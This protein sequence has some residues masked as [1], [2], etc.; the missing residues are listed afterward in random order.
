MDSKAKESGMLPVVPVS[1][2]VSEPPAANVVP[3]V[4]RRR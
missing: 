2:T 3:I 1:S 4:T